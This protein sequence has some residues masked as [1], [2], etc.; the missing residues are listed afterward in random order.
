MRKH[1]MLPLPALLVLCVAF[2]ATAAR[3]QWIE[4]NPDF[5]NT[6]DGA[7]YPVRYSFHQDIG[8]RFHRLDSTDA[9]SRLGIFIPLLED[10]SG[11]LVFADLQPFV[12]NAGNFGSNLGG[13]W[14]YYSSNLDRVF[15][16]YS[17]F[18]FRETGAVSLTQGSVGFDTLGNN[19]DARVNAYFADQFRHPVSSEV[20]APRLE[21]HHLIGGYQQAMPGGDAEAGIVLPEVFGTQSRIFGGAYYYDTK[22]DED[23]KGVRFRVET[24]W[25][26]RWTS[27]VSYAKDDVFGSTLTVTIGVNFQP[28]SFHR[29]LPEIF[30]FRRGETRH[31]TR[32]AA[33]RLAEPVH[34]EWLIPYRTG[35][36][37]LA[38]NPATGQPWH[39]THADSMVGPGGDGT[40]E[41]PFNTLADA[42]MNAAP[43]GIVYTPH[44]G[45]YNPTNPLLVPAGVQLL[46]N[47]P[48]QNLPI[49]N[50]EF[51]LPF[52]GA[53]TLPTIAGSLQLEARSKIDGFDIDS[54]IADVAAI[55]STSQTT[56][57]RN[58]IASQGD[59]VHIPDGDDVN[60]RDNE[61][62]DVAGDGI[63]ISSNTFRG[64]ITRNLIHD[65]IG[66]NGIRISAGQQ[67]TISENMI[68]D[69]MMN[70]ILINA[71]GLDAA[72]NG[73]L[74]EGPGMHGIQVDAA[75]NL[76]ITGNTIRDAG[77]NGLNIAAP[78]FGGSISGN[79]FEN[80]TAGGP[81]KNA[82]HV[83]AAMNNVEISDNTIRRMQENGIDI[84]GGDSFTITGNT[85][86]ESGGSGIHVDADTFQGAVIRNMISMNKQSAVVFM[87]AQSFSGQMVDNQ[88]F[89]S[90]DGNMTTE[91][92]GLYL[93]TGRVQ[94]GSTISGNVFRD[95]E[96]EGLKI[97][98]NGP[99][100][101]ELNITANTFTNNNSDGRQLHATL[102]DG[103]GPLNITLFQNT[104]M[105]VLSGM[106]APFNYDFT[107]PDGSAS[108]FSVL[109]FGNTGSIGSSEGDVELTEE[110]PEN[111]LG[112]INPGAGGGGM[113]PSP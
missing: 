74:V 20:V 15:G 75:T 32:Q 42:L 84:T 73:N 27:D 5:W 108:E 99:G 113:P 41:N 8:N 17:Y 101:S 2:F 62:H 82:I 109:H 14:R 36:D 40:I 52:S 11:H 88:I 64:A 58:V 23:A 1:D 19:V 46:S 83:A 25:A 102:A 97:L 37:L 53:T 60:I 79:V 44:G 77:Q 43:G 112:G 87:L 107:K 59:G 39:F 80:T 78:M 92:F 69:V 34:R 30:S 89:T 93:E 100:E 106:T 47:G 50:G 91:E 48:I 66:Q 49:P 72:I 3:G 13:G 24:N 4:V 70:G 96:H 35:D 54:D 94:L 68:R 103:A 21:G 28:E 38:T 63:F 16:V 18:D 22:L 7:G 12:D 10:A 111:V 95:N 71:S 29:R 67:A 81:M 9:V 26:P 90:G 55:T 57:S 85:I 56:I 51:R 104:S 6:R 105:P 45:T 98:V 76:A 61:I 33:D 31:I 86:M 65:G 110:D